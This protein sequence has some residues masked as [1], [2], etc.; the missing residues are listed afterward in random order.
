MPPNRNGL[1]YRRKY[2]KNCVV[3][4][5]PG[6]TT[7]EKM[8]NSI[9]TLIDSTRTEEERQPDTQYPDIVREAI[10]VFECTWN[11]D[12][13]LS[14]SPDSIENHFVL[15]IDKIVMQERWRDRMFKGKGFPRLP[16][17]YGYRNNTK[18]WFT[19]G[20]R[21]YAVPIP[22][23]KAITVDA[24][25][26]AADR[27]D[28]DIAWQRDAC[29]KLVKVPRVFLTR[30]LTQCAEAAKEEGIAEITPEFLDRV[31]DRRNKD[32]GNT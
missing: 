18:F 2:T 32:R 9:F 31:R 29:A 14:Y 28:P 15:T 13:P 20:P 19:R 17:D 12:H 3:L 27:I 22:K 5:Y 21:P 1:E 24:V 25:Q 30:V 7:S 10:Q 6:E 11:R 26:Y 23:S 8:Q 16:I 4:G